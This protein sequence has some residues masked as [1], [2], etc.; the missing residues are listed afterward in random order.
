MTCSNIVN[1][2]V[3]ADDKLLPS[4][5]WLRIVTYN[6]PPQSILKGPPLN[7]SASVPDA[8]SAMAIVVSLL[9]FSPFLA[10]VSLPL[11]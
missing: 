1:I 8:F 3:Q 6:I 5:T 4:L 10:S 11:M 2:T 7:N 9:D